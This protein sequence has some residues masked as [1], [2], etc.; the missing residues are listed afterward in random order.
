M[1]TELL[2]WYTVQDCKTWWTK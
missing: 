2:S 1:E